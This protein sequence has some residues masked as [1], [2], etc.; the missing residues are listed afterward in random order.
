MKLP[1]YSDD[2]EG[3][4][5]IHNVDL[6]DGVRTEDREW[7]PR[8]IMNDDH[9]GYAVV[10]GNGNSRVR[11]QFSLEYIENHSGGLLANKRCQT[12]GCNAI[13]RDMKPDFTITMLDDMT[14]EIAD[15]GFSENNIVYTTARNVVKYPGK[16][17]LIPQNI[18]Y[19]NSGT[20]A[21]YLACFDKHK[22]VYLIGF[23]NQRDT[24][25]TNNV[26]ADTENYPSSTEPS[27][28][29]KWIAHMKVIFDSYKDV[30]FHW[31]NDNP[32]YTFPDEWKWCKNVKYLDYRT[33]ISD[34]DI[35]VQLKYNW[36]D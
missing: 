7:I 12:Y 26:Y 36:K 28:D 6:T 4:F 27:S 31:V 18:S 5:V 14:K 10:V 20:I 15:S 25:L 33:F 32:S 24:E 34:M 21:T 22:E 35:G 9:R 11:K 8:T 23:D 29:S 13:Y 16:F 2:Y 3:E 19:Y 1:F 30:N 17:H